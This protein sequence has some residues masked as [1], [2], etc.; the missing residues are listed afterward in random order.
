MA[1]DYEDINNLDQMDGRDLRDLVR[2]HLAAHN[3]IDLDEINVQIEGETLV[4]L[5]GRVG[6]DGERRIAEHILT[7]QLGI[8]DFRNDLVV[9]PIRRAQSPEA[10]DD[11]LVDEERS[12]GLMLGDRAVPFS[13]EAEHLADDDET[14][15]AGTANV[16]RAIEGAQSWVPPESPTQEG[17]SGNDATPG[18]LGEQ[19]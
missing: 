11:H 16:H 5:S 8:Q 10:I 6:T 17:F 2:E 12:E 14:D 9:D 3:G 13:P 4:V 18:E 1:R 7:D 15:I 19:H